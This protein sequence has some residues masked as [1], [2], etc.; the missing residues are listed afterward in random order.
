MATVGLKVDG[1]TVNLADGVSFTSANDGMNGFSINFNASGAEASYRYIE[2]AKLSY[3]VSLR[4]SE[5]E[6]LSRV[7]ANGKI[8]LTLASDGNGSVTTS[9]DGGNVIVTVAPNE[10]YVFD[11]WYSGDAKITNDLVISANTVLTAKFAAK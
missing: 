7:S 8:L 6:E 11:G 9:C 1:N 4:N 5:G 2:M 3:Y 10:G